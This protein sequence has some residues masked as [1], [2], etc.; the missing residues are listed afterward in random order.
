[1][2]LTANS[3]IERAL[4]K[5]RVYYPGEA[6]PEAKA[7]QIFAEL[8][9]MLESWALEELMVV[10]DVLESF[11]LVIG[12]AEYTYGVGGNFNSPRPID[13][14]DD[15]F[16]RAGSTDYP[17]ALKTVDFYRGKANKSTSGDPEIIAYNP[18]Y[19]LGKVMLYPTPSATNNLHLRVRKEINRFTDRT[20]SIELEPGY[21]RAIISNLAVEISPNFGKKVSETLAY[22][23]TQSKRSIKSVNSTPTKP[24]SCPDL[25]L[26]VNR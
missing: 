21:S 16:I 19:P 25:A 18:E 9:D 17:V 5:A 6:I 2:E 13:I 1:M 8:N 24:R 10:A 23:A 4:V 22:V 12:Q 20:T 14:R 26:M 7:A 11:A 3:I 15:S